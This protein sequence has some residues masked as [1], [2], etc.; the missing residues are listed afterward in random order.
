ME[1]QK[2]NEV[3]HLETAGRYIADF[4]YGANDGIIT[5]FAIIAASAGAGISAGVILILGFAN[6]VA[7]GFS[8]ATSNYLGIKSRRDFEIEQKRLEVEEIEI[9]PE[10]ERQE[11]REIF[12]KKGFRGADLERAVEIIVSNKKVWVDEMLTG[13]LGIIPEENIKS[14]PIRHAIATFF[15]FATIGLIPILPY[16]FGYS[17]NTGFYASM[18]LTGLSLFIVG[19]SRVSITGGGFFKNGFQM[20]LTGGFAAFAA[21][22]IGFIVRQFT[23]L[24]L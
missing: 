11:V 9:R 23:G 24:S 18:F 13:E 12:S 17:G 2:Y 21:Y 20:L 5:T 3:K 1:H 4:V 15:S 14:T 22:A 10:E 19:G 8:M 7:D 16:L 6:L